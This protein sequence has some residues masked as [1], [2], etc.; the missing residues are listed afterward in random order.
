MLRKRKCIIWAMNI[1][2]KTGK[3]SKKG[4]GVG[5]KKR[6]ALDYQFNWYP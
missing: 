4:K 2:S 6:K 1:Q 3:A 5:R